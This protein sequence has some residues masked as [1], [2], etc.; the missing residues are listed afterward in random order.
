[1]NESDVVAQILE[2]RAQ[3]R[4]DVAHV[5]VL[6][7]ATRFAV[8]FPLLRLSTT[9]LALRHPF[10]PLLAVNVLVMALE[11]ALTGANTTTS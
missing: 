10:V 9:L 4:A 5:P 7:G 6:R 11:V 8:G 2:S 3:F 1:M